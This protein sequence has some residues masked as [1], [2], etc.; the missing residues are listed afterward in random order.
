MVLPRWLARFN[1][2]VTNR[3]LGLIPRRISPFVIIHHRG[4]ISGRPYATLG[5]AFPTP[6]GFVLS[7]GASWRTAEF[8]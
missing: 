1:R 3:V 2:R 7:S 6:E 8:S 5:A 4:R